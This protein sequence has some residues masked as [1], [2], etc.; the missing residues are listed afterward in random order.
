M[1]LL[2]LI[3]WICLLALL[4][5]IVL[6]TTL[7]LFAIEE[8]PLVSAQSHT[9]NQENVSRIKQ[10]LRD[11][12][13]RRL[14]LGESRTVTLTEADSNLLLD[15]GLQQLIN[16]AAVLELSPQKARLQLSLPLSPWLKGRYFNTQAELT[17]MDGRYR[18]Q[19]WQLGNLA[20]PDL[21]SQL[22]A[23]LSHLLLM[24]YEPYQV[25]L[26]STEAL[27]FHADQLEVRFY[28]HQ[29]LKDQLKQTGRQWVL[30]PEDQARIAFYQ[31]Q[32]YRSARG[33]QRHQSLTNLLAPL[34][35]QAQ[36]RSSTA[37][38]AVAENRALLLT[39]SFYLLRMD[40]GQYISQRTPRLTYFWL[41]WPTLAGRHD[42]A[43]HFG[44]SA[45]ITAAAG[46][47]IADAAGVFKELKDS[48]GG[49]GFS[50][51]D[52][53]ADITGQRFAKHALHPATAQALQ[54]Q[55]AQADTEALFMPDIQHLPEG[56]Q[57]TAFTRRYANLDN[58]SYR[59]ALAEIEQR[60]AACG[61]YQ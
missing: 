29:L 41:R 58:T 37:E 61:L 8:Q 32:L 36:Q 43:Q 6:P 53:A 35:A 50:F 23:E 11:A 12:N 48:Q 40:V 14:K 25:G 39:V 10:V 57:Q 1:W 28:W 44:V 52:L 49:S 27:N 46:S 2:K 9:L 17:Q 56:L 16:G 51:A 7:L 59:Q 15:Y 34:F 60:I 47:R 4:V 21:I 42:L 38:Q 30:T 55:M 22:L 19:R 13:P 3:K 33:I 5:G 24:K 45:G 54:Q 31:Q 26:M 20:I 18:L